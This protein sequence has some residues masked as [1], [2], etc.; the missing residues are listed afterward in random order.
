MIDI[1]STVFNY[2]A[3]ALRAEF[4]GISVYG[5][6]VEV[7]S[8]FPS[9]SLVEE[10]NTE[11]AGNKTLARMP[12]TA[13][14]LMYRAQVYSNLQVGKKA[15]TKAIIKIV[16]EAMHKFG[17]NRDFCNQLANIDRTIYRIVAQYTKTFQ[18]F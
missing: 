13:C 4:P 7:P 15:Q 17:F 2:V 6:E 3:N 14:S 1:E 18:T 12:E 8:S 5:E 10:S 11:I 9:V 16:D